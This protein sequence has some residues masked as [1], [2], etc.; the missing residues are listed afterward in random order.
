MN[1]QDVPFSTINWEAM[2]PT[3][4]PGK[5]GIIIS[6]VF[7]MG[8]IHVRMVEFTPGFV[9]NHW[10]SKGHMLHV[11]EGDLITELTDGRKFV[12][13]AGQSFAIPDDLDAHRDS[14]ETG[15]RVLIVD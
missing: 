11:L 3:A 15:A 6:R 12:S 8:N 1:I 9:A 7:E 5:K 4:H 14:T 13:T 2:T 10:C